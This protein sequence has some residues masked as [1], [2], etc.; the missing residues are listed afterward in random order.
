MK[1]LVRTGAAVVAAGV[2]GV[3]AAGPAAAHFCFKT[4]RNA[5]STAAIAGSQ[6]WV[7]FA[8]I[9][10]TE[11]PGLCEAGIAHIATAA[12]ATPDTMIKA[13]G[14]MAGGT[15]RKAEPGTSSISHLDFDALFAAVP[16]AFALCGGGV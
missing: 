15:L 14:V 7:S 3:A 9:A 16:D 8:D 4:N 13:H 12:G 2:M 1:F 5:T 6:G 10:R 11:L